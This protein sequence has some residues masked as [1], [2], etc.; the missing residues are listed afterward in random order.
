[1]TAIRHEL[2]AQAERAC[3]CLGP[4]ALARAVLVD[5]APSPA[6]DAEFGLLALADGS[7]GL[8]YAWLGGE[9][10]SLPLRF[11]AADLEGLDVLEVCRLYLGDSDVDRSLGLAA[12]SAVTASLYRCAGYVAPTAD[13]A[14]AGLTLVAGDRLGMVGNFPPLVRRARA[15]GVDVAV[16]ERK[17][18]M[19][20]AAPGLAISLDPRVLHDREQVICTGATLLND[21]FEAVLADCRHARR[22]ALVGPTVGFFPDSVFARGVDVVAGT[23]VLD[24]EQART[25]LA[26]GLRMGASAERTLIRRDDYPGFESLLARAAASRAHTADVSGG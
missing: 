21:T 22:I 18:H 19:V 13:D 10:A 25:R 15:L 26:A 6:R 16:L 11:R 12:I 3:E 24:V 8:Y 9:Q 1:M 4:Q 5:P 17:A 7:S 20:T 23:R 14:F 2:F